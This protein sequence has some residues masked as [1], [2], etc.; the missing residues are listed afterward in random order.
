MERVGEREKEIK[1]ETEMGEDRVIT[2]Q[3]AL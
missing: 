2:E 1:K 3:L